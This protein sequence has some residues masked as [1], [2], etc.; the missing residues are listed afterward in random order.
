M[1]RTKLNQQPAAKLGL[2]NADKSTSGIACR[3]ERRTTPPAQPAQRAASNSIGALQLRCG[4][5][6]RRSCSPARKPASSDQ[7]LVEPAQ[8]RLAAV[9]PQTQATKAPRVDI[10]RVSQ[11]VSGIA[12]ISAIR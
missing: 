4:A 9:K 7:K 5:S 6:L 1:P 11:P 10:I 2:R 3:S 8:A 12:T